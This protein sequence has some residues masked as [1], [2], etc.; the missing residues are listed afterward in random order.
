M[1][2]REATRNDITEIF[3]LLVFAHDES[4]NYSDSP[5][6]RPRVESM[7]GLLIDNPR[8]IVLVD[9]EV[10][11]VLIGEIVPDWKSLGD[12][13]MTHLIYAKPET[14]GKGLALLRHFRKWVSLWGGV[15]KIVI[16]TSFGGDR[17]DRTHLLLERLGF[18]QVGRQY[19][20]VI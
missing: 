5:Y 7:L 14:K 8:A 19:V 2:I 3:N 20:E 11:M 4:D 9:D 15:K 12:V 10:D 6:S 13:A 16:A 1:E 18:K 17:G